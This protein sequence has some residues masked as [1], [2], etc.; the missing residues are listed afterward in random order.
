MRNLRQTVAQAQNDFSIA[1]TDSVPDRGVEVCRWSFHIT[2][3]TRPIHTVSERN[4]LSDSQAIDCSVRVD[5]WDGS[6]LLCSFLDRGV[7]DW[8][9]AAHFF[10][11]LSL[12]LILL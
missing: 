7:S 2:T 6:T 4:I 1:A 8:F 3:P 12:M 5:S 9:L 10:E 11:Y